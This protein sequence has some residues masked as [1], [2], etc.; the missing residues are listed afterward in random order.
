[1]KTDNYVSKKEA[2]QRS[3]GELSQ[4]EMKECEAGVD[5]LREF[6][7]PYRAYFVFKLLKLN[8]EL[9]DGKP[10]MKTLIDLRRGTIEGSDYC[11]KCNGYLGKAEDYE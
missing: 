10:G 4:A 5:F 2:V 6:P 11:S 3:F 8:K 9:S 1:M 7:A